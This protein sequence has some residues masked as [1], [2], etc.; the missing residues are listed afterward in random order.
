MSSVSGAEQFRFGIW[1]GCSLLVEEQ[2]RSGFERLWPTWVEACG[3]NA[4]FGVSASRKAM[5]IF[6]TPEK[7]TFKSETLMQPCLN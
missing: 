7:S 3:K 1:N 6:Q 4:S 2:R 5:D